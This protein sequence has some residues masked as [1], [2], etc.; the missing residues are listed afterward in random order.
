MSEPLSCTEG[1][2]VIYRLITELNET[3]EQPPYLAMK[4][5][6]SRWYPVQNVFD[7]MQK[8]AEMSFDKEPSYRLKTAEG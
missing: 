4:I 6:D 3:S 7:V 8:R 2:V 5:D 1:P